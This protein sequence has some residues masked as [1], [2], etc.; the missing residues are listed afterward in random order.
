[1]REPGARSRRA[2][3]T[4]VRASDFTPDTRGGFW[5]ALT[6]EDHSRTMLKWVVGEAGRS[7]KS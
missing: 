5:R 6:L 3:Q 7:V 4:A 2:L 1:M